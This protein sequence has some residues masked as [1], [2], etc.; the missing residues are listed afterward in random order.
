MG[1]WRWQQVQRRIEKVKNLNTC[2]VTGVVYLD[3]IDKVP[4]EGLK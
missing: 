2:G 3:F 4:F 1:Q